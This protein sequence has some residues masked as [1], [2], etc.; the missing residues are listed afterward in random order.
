MPT[1]RT[2][3]AVPEG[4]KFDERTYSNAAGSR[5]YKL[6]VP[7]GYTGQPVPLVVMLHGCTQSLTT[8]P[9]ARG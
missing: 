3:I 2:S 5:A 8:L 1:G 4:A 9:P 6:Y 7:S